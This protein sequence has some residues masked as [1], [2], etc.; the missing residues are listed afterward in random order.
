M[1]R[2]NGRLLAQMPLRFRGGLVATD[3]TMYGRQGD[4]RNIFTGAFQQLNG[5]PSGHLAPSSWVLPQKPGAMSAF[6]GVEFAWTVPSLTVAAGINIEGT[7]PIS[8]TVP[9]SQLQLI[10][11]LAGTS[12][13]SWTVPNATLGGAAGMTGTSTITFTVPN[14]ILGGSA[15]MTGT[16]NITFA[17]TANLTALA[18][19]SAPAPDAGLTNESIANAVDEKLRPRFN[20]LGSLVAA[21]L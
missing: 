9:A 15:G 20:A 16:A 2:Q 4:R 18:F 19:M 3:R 12:T 13:I 14:A 1:L 21:G 17:S 10:A 11:D 6:T 7:S 8:W 5:I